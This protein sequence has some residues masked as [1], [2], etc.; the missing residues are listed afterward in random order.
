MIV[1]CIEGLAELSGGLV[2]YAIA[3]E[4]VVDLSTWLDRWFGKALRL[5]GKPSSI[6]LDLFL[7]RPII[8]YY[9]A[10]SLGFS[11]FDHIPLDN[12]R[13]FKLFRGIRAWETH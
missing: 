11:D 1:G 12:P 8:K 7:L 6:G 4:G 5:K 10:C 2:T 9:Q 13:F 3:G